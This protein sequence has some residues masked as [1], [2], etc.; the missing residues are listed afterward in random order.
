M[1]TIEE[2]TLG[3]AWL[4]TCRRILDHGADLA[5]LQQMGALAA[6]VA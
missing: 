2:W 6:S 3:A 5:R 4:E 1:E